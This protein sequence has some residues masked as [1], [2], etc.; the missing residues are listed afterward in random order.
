M[1]GGGGDERPSWAVRRAANTY[2]LLLQGTVFLS[3]VAAEDPA[4]TKT[5]QGSYE[6]SVKH[7]NSGS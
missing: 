4:K 1:S 6:F 5:F 2:V 3:H 7:L